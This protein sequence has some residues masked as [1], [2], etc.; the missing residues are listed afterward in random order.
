MREEG[1]IAQPEFHV[2]GR[3]TGRYAFGVEG[4]LHAHVHTPFFG[5]VCRKV[6]SKIRGRNEGCVAR[7]PV[8]R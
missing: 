8:A 6:M 7:E 5:F 4:F 3:S 2:L 1:G